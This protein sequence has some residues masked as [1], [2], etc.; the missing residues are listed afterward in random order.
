M[1]LQVTCDII[2]ISPEC[3]LGGLFCGS[4]QTKK[5]LKAETHKIQKS[6]KSVYWQ[7]ARKQTNNKTKIFLSHPAGGVLFSDLMPINDLFTSSNCDSGSKYSTQSWTSAFKQPAEP[8]T[9][10]TQ[11]CF[12]PA[13]ELLLHSSSVQKAHIQTLSRLVKVGT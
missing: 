2:Y 4:R 12:S 11:L 9:S 10:V 6:Y 1:N 13:D 5:S 8:Q 3:Q 7:Q